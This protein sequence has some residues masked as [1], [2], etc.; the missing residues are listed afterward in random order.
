[1]FFQGSL[2]PS[3]ARTRVTHKSVLGVQKRSE[4]MFNIT[5]LSVIAPEIVFMHRHAMQHLNQF[6]LLYLVVDVLTAIEGI[7]GC[8]V[9]DAMQGGHGCGEP[10]LFQN[11]LGN[12]EA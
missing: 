2:Q 9:E 5:A 3:R 6:S 1:M 12:L 7:Q 11:C 4:E 8:V 10:G